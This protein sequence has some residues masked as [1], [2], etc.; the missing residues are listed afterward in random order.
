MNHQHNPCMETI[1]SQQHG[2]TYIPDT[3]LKSVFV[4]WPEY[5]NA[6]FELRPAINPHFGKAECFVLDVEGRKRAFWHRSE[7]C[8]I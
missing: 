6:T 2:K 8:G 5:R 4:D 1:D 7:E 3:L